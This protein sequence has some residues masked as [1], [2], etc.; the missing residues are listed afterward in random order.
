MIG[1]SITRTAA[2]HQFSQ[3]GLAAI[4][5][6]TQAQTR[7]I[8]VV[9]RKDETLSIAAAGMLELIERHIGQEAFGGMARRGRGAKSAQA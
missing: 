2:R 8:L 6:H 4:P 7:P 5:L 3:L 1:A 9:T